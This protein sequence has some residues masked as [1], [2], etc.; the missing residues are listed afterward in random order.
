MQIDR[1][2]FRNIMARFGAAVSIVTTEG[3]AGRCGF[4]CTAVCSVT[5]D[6][7]TILVCL[8]RSSQ[9]N[10]VFKSNGVLCVN[11]LGAGQE[12]LSATF[13]GQTG[14]GM[15]DRFAQDRWDALVTGAPALRDAVGA[16][17]CTIADIKEFG[18]HT[19]LF[20]KVVSARLD[21]SRDSLV[22]FNR[23][24]HA[25]PVAPARSQQGTLALTNTS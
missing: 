7:A 12:D 22:Y 25:L 20:G 17:D 10:S 9:M 23:Q 5:D 21:S 2:A 14:V 4:T 15:A 18:T 11:V 1:V 13:A 6:P 16:L 3:A 19:I 8:N 24:Y